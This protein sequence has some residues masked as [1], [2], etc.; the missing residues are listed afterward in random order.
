METLF[1]AVASALLGAVVMYFVMKN[2]PRRL[3]EAEDEVSRRVLQ[4]ELSRAKRIGY[5]VLLVLIQPP[6]GRYKAFRNWIESE[7]SSEKLRNYDIVLNWDSDLL[8]AV[9]PVADAKVSAEKIE[10]RLK[11][12]L[13]DGEWAD[14]K[15]GFSVYP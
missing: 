3:R 2:A 15:Y 6:E 10:Q 1:I 11:A 7:D 9:L 13:S 5:A 14:V 12:L 8:V 4:L